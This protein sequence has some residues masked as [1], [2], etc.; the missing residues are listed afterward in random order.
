MEN[1]RHAIEVQRYELGTTKFGY[2]PS[3]AL[4]EQA[5]GRVK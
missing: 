5:G 4:Y 1:A 2:Q 3:T